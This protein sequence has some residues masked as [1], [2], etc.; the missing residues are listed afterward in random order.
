RDPLLEAPVETY[1]TIDHELHEAV[2]H[3]LVGIAVELRG[4][5]GSQA[6]ARQPVTYTVN[7]A[8]FG[9]AIAQERQQHINS[10]EHDPGR[11][12]LPSL[13]LENGQHAGQLEFPGLHDRRGE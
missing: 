12:E 5:D 8:H 7:L 9:A 2:V 11:A 13:R 3:G 4:D 6:I 10:V 1:Y